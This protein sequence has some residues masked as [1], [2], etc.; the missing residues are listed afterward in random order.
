MES[1]L[2][3]DQHAEQWYRRFWILSLLSGIEEAGCSPIELRGFNLLAYLANAV[4][5]CYGVAALDPTVLKR[6]DGPLY[7][8]LIWDLDRLVGMQL[9]HVSN[10]VIDQQ[11]KPRNV[12]YGIT[13]RG[14][15]VLDK[16]RQL[17]VTLGKTA[18]ALR[19]TAL[20]YARNKLHLTSEVVSQ[21]DGNYSDTR[22]MEGSVV[23]FGAWSDVNASANSVE[24]ILSQVTTALHHDPG[25]GVNLYAQYLGRR[26]SGLPLANAGVEVRA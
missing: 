14:L 11:N 1:S 18:E 26:S 15:K 22:V 3:L 21:F 10:V 23:D 5:R 4:A 6:A 2:N 19:S 24:Y 7:P 25:L 13:A 8:L 20:A 16:C 9:V 12:S 17:Q